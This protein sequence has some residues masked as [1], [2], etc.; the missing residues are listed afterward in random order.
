MYLSIR[1]V[2]RPGDTVAV[3]SPTYYA[4]LEVVASL[5]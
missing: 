1:A 2:T 5:G 3:E 4:L